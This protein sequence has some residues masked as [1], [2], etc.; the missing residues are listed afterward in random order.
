MPAPSRIS[1][2]RIERDERPGNR[3]WFETTH[4]TVVRQAG[5]ADPAVVAEALNVLCRTYWSAVRVYVLRQCRDPH[6]ADDLT[7][8]FFLRFLSREHYRLADPA[9]GR[10]RSFLLT[11]LKRH[12]INAQERAQAQKRG[13]GQ[14]FVSLDCGSASGNPQLTVTDDRTAEHA[15]ERQW[16][17]ALLGRVRERLQAEFRAAGRSDRFEILEMFLPGIG[18]DS[19]YSAVASQLGVPEGTLKSD[20]HRLKRRYR[21]FLQE[22]VAHTLDAPADIHEE[23]KYLTAVLARTTSAQID[24]S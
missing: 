12:L 11:S 21:D 14:Q 13:G 18:N 6:E 7:Q 20:V 8:D 16:A 5:S 9:R 1:N 23:L 2:S 10:F 15:F 22:E 19:S 3:S 4:W 17:L 24:A